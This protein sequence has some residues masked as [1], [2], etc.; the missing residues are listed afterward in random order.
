MTVDAPAEADF[1]PPMTTTGRAF[2]ETGVIGKYLGWVENSYEDTH[3]AILAI[4]S[5]ARAPLLLDIAKLVKA[6]E[7][8]ERRNVRNLAR[9]RA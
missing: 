8:R 6:G 2:L 3:E 5:E 9:G 4:E 1:A 7:K